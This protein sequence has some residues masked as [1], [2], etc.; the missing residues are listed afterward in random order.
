MGQMHA[1]AGR[2]QS[3]LVPVPLLLCSTHTE[4]G[5]LWP[6]PEKDR[7]DHSRWGLGPR[8]I[9]SKLLHLSG[10]FITISE[11]TPIGRLGGRAHLALVAICKKRG[12][13]H[14]HPACARLALHPK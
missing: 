10:L 2:P 8:L 1:Q 14:S 5:T 6:E 11:N 12:G 3:G 9:F 4:N 13:L 7:T